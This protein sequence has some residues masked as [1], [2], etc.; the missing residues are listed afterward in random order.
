MN[1]KLPC[2]PLVTI[3][4]FMSI[5]SKTEKLYD[6][7]TILWCD[8][9]KKMTAIVTIDGKDY[10]FMGLGDEPAIEQIKID[11]SPLITEYIFK[12]EKIVLS[13]KFWT[14]LFV[15]NIYELSLP[16][17]F[18]DCSVRSA[19]GEAH[20]VFVKISLDKD[21]CYERI[22]KLISKE[23]ITQNGITYAVMGRKNQKP[24]SKSGDGLSA[25]WGNICLYGEN[26]SV[27]PVFR[28]GI[29]AY[30][31]AQDNC[32]F[33]I[34]FDDLES[35]EYMGEKCKGLWT[36][37]LY[38]IGNAIKYCRDNYDILY[39]KALL[40]NDRILCDAA[41]FGEDYQAILTAAYRQIL[42]AHKLVR[43][44]KGE[45][46]Y[47]SKECHSNGCINTVDISYPSIPFYLFYNPEL[48]KGMM[49]GIFEF[50]RTDAW[51]FDFAPHD[52]GTYPIANGQAYGLY[53]SYALC[54]SSLY[55]S[56]RNVYNL[57]SQMPV[58]ECGNML[59][60]AYTHFLYSGDRSVIEGNYDLLLKWAEYL[61]N[62]GVELENQLCTDDFAGHSEKNINLAIKG[63]M[64]LAA[65]AKISEAMNI[66]NEYMKYAKQ[67]A[68]KLMEYTLDCKALPF[69]VGDSNTW[70][71]KYNLVWDILLDFNLF[72]ENLYKAESELYR[73]KLNEYGVPL[74]YRKAFSKTD[75]MMWASTLDESA[76]N[77]KLF[78][79]LIRKFLAE[80][81]DK[82]CFSDWINTDTP[83]HAGFSHR[84]VQGGLWLP[85]LMK[86]KTIGY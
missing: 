14:P 16:C 86:R 81:T 78:A 82:V 30:G 72:D 34:A 11:V 65:F 52:I 10:R 50:A 42:A 35:I 70:S 2:Y 12:N 13:V 8:I 6:S 17:S 45:L 43:N 75:W 53:N 29:S 15:D 76:D 32:R 18:I 21:F 68:N 3:D 57:N 22:Q 41:V 40:W 63:I 31:E 7:D 79:K 9:K 36:E 48:I 49:T 54:K 26:V 38:N 55:K 67:N 85:L 1:I 4:P 44:K 5:W 62:A 47:L 73:K 71:L 69:A 61:K 59:I 19:D 80:T 39:Q 77:T 51:Q 60:M 64:G 46:L 24:L 27:S 20:R 74:D 56:K 58:E 84:T 83:T 28:N 23:T 66:K 37:K 33:I 25:D